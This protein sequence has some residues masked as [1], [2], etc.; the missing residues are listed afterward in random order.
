M[1][2]A[3]MASAICRISVSLMLQPNV[4]QV[5]QPIGGVLATPLFSA[6]AGA[7]ERTMATDPSTNVRT[8]T[9]PIASDRVVRRGMLTGTALIVPPCIALGGPSAPAD[10]GR[11]AGPG[12]VG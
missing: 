7:A 3:T 6:W 11:C 2:L 9:T 12:S 5:F 8:N 10:Q 1:P 4:F